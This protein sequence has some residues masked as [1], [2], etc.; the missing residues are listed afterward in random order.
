MALT[1]LDYPEPRFKRAGGPNTPTTTVAAARANPRSRAF[2]F[3]LRTNATSR[4]TISTPRL[5]GP[6][7]VSGIQWGTQGNNDAANWYQDVGVAPAPS[8]K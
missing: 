4:T 3:E 5:Q 2:W 7:V 6:V 8:A 1:A